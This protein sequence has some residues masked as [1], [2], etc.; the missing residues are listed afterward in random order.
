MGW[1]VWIRSSWPF[2][3]YCFRYRRTSVKVT[4]VEHEGAH[5]HALRCSSSVEIEKHRR[6]LRLSYK[7]QG[8]Q[9]TK[10]AKL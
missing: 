8:A 4:Y 10:G 5:L 7:V 1:L 6:S 9:V 2:I 3:Q